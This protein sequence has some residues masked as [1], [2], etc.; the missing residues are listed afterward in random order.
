MRNILLFIFNLIILSFVG[1][2]TSTTIASGSGNFTIPCGVTTITVQVWGGGGGGGGD[3]TANS[4]GG[5]GGSAGGYVTTTMNVTSSSVYGYTVGAGGTGGSNTSAGTSGGNSTFGS[6]VAFGG[7]GGLANSSTAPA[8]V[9][10]SGGTVTSG[11]A[12]TGGGANGGTGG[13]AG[14][15]GGGAGGAGGSGGTDGSNGSAPGGG[16]GGADDEGG[17]SNSGGNGG[18]GQIIIKYTTP[19]TN[20]AGSNQTLANCATTANM[21]ATALPSN[22]SGY[23]LCSSNCA[24]VSIT[25]PSSTTSGVTGLSPGV[26]TT[27]SWVTTYTSG[28]NVSQTVSITSPLGTPCSTAVP[29]N[30]NCASAI[31]ITPGMQVSG[32][33]LNSTNDVYSGITGIGPGAVSCTHNGNVWYQFTTGNAPL[34]CYTFQESWNTSGCNTMIMTTSCAGGVI[35]TNVSTN[36][37]NDYS[38]TE[39]STALAPNTTYYVSLGSSV[40]GPF[41]FSLTAATAATND[42]CSGAQQIGTFPL[43]TDN[44]AA[45]CEY[46]YVSSQDANVAAAT[47]CAG[48]LENISWFT[49]TAVSSGTV[50]ITVSNILCNN[51]GG[52][53]QTGIITGSCSTYTVGTSGSAICVAASS[54]TVTYNIN[55][56]IAGQTYLIGMDGNAGS[57][58]HFSISGTNILPLPIELSKFSVQLNGNFVDAN[59]T[60][61]SEKNNDFFTLER[62]SDALNFEPIAVV[63]GAGTSSQQHSYFVQ[64]KAPLTGVSYYRLK[65][66]DYNKQSTYSAIHTMSIKENN[67]F[68]FT[69]YPKPSFENEEM[70]LRFQ[71]EQNEILQVLITD[72]SGKILSDKEFK[73]NANVMEVELKHNFRP[74]I[75]FIKVLNKRGDVVNQKFV[76]Q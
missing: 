7:P 27:F 44:A 67:T 13:T 16:G 4:I 22:W 66:T 41:S 11:G 30:N 42:Q 69:L 38:S 39:N 20:S 24:G 72:I 33:T 51:G 73:L 47:L 71:G 3:G 61:A 49:F 65:Q 76:V 52:G 32:T 18:A 50:T 46:T 64:D 26:T 2:T 59:W 37:Y 62:S 45:G 55:S 1:Q 74:G 6:V 14:G 60:T 23:W 17:A 25:T 58:C 68:D 29:S 75:Y 5:A 31:T 35:G 12:G 10:G 28:C 48:S 40:Q 43:Q 15:P 63:K 53:F 34:P 36:I 56:A 8:S 19:P 54:G 9:G 70:R 57:N 21:A